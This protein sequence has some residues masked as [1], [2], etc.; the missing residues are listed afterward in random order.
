MQPAKQQLWALTIT[1]LLC[2]N[3]WARRQCTFLGNMTLNSTIHTWLVINLHL[4]VFLRQTRRPRCRSFMPTVSRQALEPR[5]L[6]TVTILIRCGASSTANNSIL[7]ATSS[8][9]PAPGL[10]YRPGPPNSQPSNYAAPKANQNSTAKHRNTFQR[11]SQ[12]SAAPTSKESSIAK[13]GTPASLPPKPPP[14]ASMKPAGFDEQRLSS[15]LPARSNPQSNGV[16][17]TDLVSSSGTIEPREK[18]PSINGTSRPSEKT[19]E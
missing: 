16:R 6:G 15:S 19:A 2:L 14:P 10:L 9:H 12:P 18:T 3:Q 5:E 13:W 4:I 17:N 11:K 7:K 1:P 8:H